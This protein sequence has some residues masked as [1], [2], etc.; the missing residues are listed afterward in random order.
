MFSIEIE[1]NRQEIIN[2]ESGG[3]PLTV[4]PRASYVAWTQSYCAI[5]RHEPIVPTESRTGYEADTPKMWVGLTCGGL[6]RANSSGA[7]ELVEPVALEYGSFIS[8]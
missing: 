7:C 4:A 6:L 5:S 3:S 1:T 8:G 2:S